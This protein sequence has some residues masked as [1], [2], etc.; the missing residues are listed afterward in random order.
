MLR[1]FML[2]PAAVIWTGCLSPDCKNEI[3]KELVS[4]DGINKA[5]IFSRNCGATTGYNC[6]ASILPAGDLL[7][8]DTGNA[9]IFY[10]PGAEVSWLDSKTL[11]AL[12]RGSARA[13]R[14]EEAVRGVKLVYRAAPASDKNVAAP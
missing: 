6:Q 4:P 5:V 11:S 8:D 2:I 10:T 9:F 7:P 1:K 12:V 3:S 14:R 13:S